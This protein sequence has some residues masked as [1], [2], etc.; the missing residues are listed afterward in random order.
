MTGC[1]D[2]AIEDRNYEYSKTLKFNVS[3]KNAEISRGALINSASDQNF[4]SFGIFAYENS[5]EFDPDKIPSSFYKGDEFKNKILEKVEPDS[6][7]LGG[8]YYWPQSNLSFFAYAPYIDNTEDSKYGM[9]LKYPENDVPVISYSMPLNVADQPDLMISVPRLNL[10]QEVADIQFSHALACI[11]FNVTGP[12]IKI[13]SLWITGISTEGEISLNYNGETMDWMNVSAPIDTTY[14][15]GIGTDSIAVDT[16]KDIMSNNGY[17]MV[18]PQT[19]TDD[20]YVMISF[21]GLDTKKVSL[22]TETISE[23]KAG[24]KYMYTLSEGEYEFKVEA[25]STTCYFIGGSIGFTVNSIY[26]SVKD[27]TKNVGWTVTIKEPADTSW[28]LGYKNL[29]DTLGGKEIK[30]IVTIPISPY[31][32]K[33]ANSYDQELQNATPYLQDAPNDLSLYVDMCYS[34]NCYI[35]NNPGWHKF[36]A[37]V[38]G[39][40][41]E[42]ASKDNVVIN[43]ENCFPKS[44][45]YFV[46]YNGN[47]IMN[48]SDL[49]IPIDG[50]TVAEVLWMDAVGLITDISITDDK[51]I[52]FN[53]PKTTI[54]QGNAVIGI[55]NREGIIMWSWHIWVSPWTLKFTNDP[56]DEYIFFLDINIGECF[57]SQYNYPERQTTL[58]FKQNESN[59]TQE[60]VLTQ[61]ESSSSIDYNCMYYQWG[62]KD[63]MISQAGEKMAPFCDGAAKF[64]VSSTSGGVSIAEAIK[65]PNIFYKSTGN[66]YTGNNDNLWKPDPDKNDKSLYD[67]SPIKYK[68]PLDTIM[69]K[70][71]MGDD[72]GWKTAYDFGYYIFGYYNGKSTQ[73]TDLILIASGYREGS[74]GDVLDNAT[75]GSYWT[76]TVESSSTSSYSV[77]FRSA[78]IENFIQKNVRS[79]G[80]AICPMQDSFQGTEN[81]S[82]YNLYEIYGIPKSNK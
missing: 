20:A 34:V 75:G 40:G 26:K 72:G 74:T 8:V 32:V 3:F 57:R 30:K 49:E 38:M 48:V 56:E 12:H 6:W 73:K 46:D 58:I 62:R 59:K 77:V 65:N 68:V 33:D 36:P 82:V 71:S 80:S 45:P 50:G 24:N 9:T 53:V 5:G 35:V 55:K 1:Q 76:S 14:C 19:V 10:N 25:D 16:V 47:D 22:K 43:N 69:D 52:L 64:A 31:T 39:N 81:E 42:K 4:N 44:A 41:I 23:W 63:P 21:N 66:W 27:T 28:L 51:Y 17:L 2:A 18:I 70:L 54:R 61:L 67:P 29:G 11:G 37:F 79:R 15:I 7:T 13:D 60:I 78:S